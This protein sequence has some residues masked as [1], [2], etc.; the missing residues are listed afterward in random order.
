MSETADIDA[1]AKALL[2]R[3]RQL[4]DEELK[5]AEHERERLLT[6][7]RQRTDQQ[8]QF[9]EA[10]A[11]QEAERAYR[12]QVQRSELNIRARIAQLRWTLINEVI[13]ELTGEL[14]KL[15]ADPSRYH[16]LLLQ[17][18]HEACQAMPDEKLIAQLNNHDYT[19][20]QQEWVQMLETSACRQAIELSEQRCECSGG[21]LI[22]NQA[23]DIRFDNTFEARLER[24]RLEIQRRISKIL[25]PHQ[26]NTEA[27]IHAG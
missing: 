7:A 14:E 16:E 26:E 12:Q 9:I 27:Q 24:L 3:A 11:R 23:D 10:Q 19:A 4:A 5:L 1:L 17:L 6:R 20:Y 2:S 22:R 25:F 13:N 21:V 8:R 18:L 15:H